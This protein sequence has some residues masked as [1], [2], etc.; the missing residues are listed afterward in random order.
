[1]KHFVHFIAQLKVARIAIVA[2]V[3]TTLKTD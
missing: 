2:F 1:M 3:E